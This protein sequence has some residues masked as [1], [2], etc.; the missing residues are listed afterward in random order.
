MRKLSEL[1]F[2]QQIIVIAVVAVLILIIF[3]LL[4]KPKI[5]QLSEISAIQEQEEQ[6]FNALN[7]TIIRLKSIKQR[8]PEIEARLAELGKSIPETAEVP[9]LLVDVQDIANQAD[10]DFLSIKPSSLIEQDSY[11]LLPFEITIDGYFYDLVDFLYRLEKLPRMLKVT[12]I[13][14]NEGEAGLPN[15]SVSITA[16][17]FVLS[18]GQAVTAVKK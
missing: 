17:A 12:K 14:I 15:I 11:A 8:A 7:A 1:E 4:L 5:S 18:K 6:E 3:T 10:I 9:S 13:L 2:K 16:N